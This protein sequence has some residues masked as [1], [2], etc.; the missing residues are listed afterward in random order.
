MEK[1]LGELGTICGLNQ[2]L[3]SDGYWANEIRILANGLA[4]SND[5]TVS[6]WGWN[7]RGEGYW[8]SVPGF[9]Q[10]GTVMGR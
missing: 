4:K 2:E 7:F 5:I 1:W 9:E 3:Y 8:D 10:V 6:E